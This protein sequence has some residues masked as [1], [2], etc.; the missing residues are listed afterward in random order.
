MIHRSIPSSYPSNVAQ[1]HLAD[2][3]AAGGPLRQPQYAEAPPPSA[4]TSPPKA[5]AIIQKIKAG[6]QEVR[7]TKCDVMAQEIG[8]RT[9]SI[10][11]ALGGR[12]GSG[13]RSPA[14]HRDMAAHRPAPDVAIE[15]SAACLG[16]QVG[17]PQEEEGQ[18]IQLRFAILILWVFLVFGI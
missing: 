15:C 5:K 13:M 7:E 6:A 11:A 12:A 16:G 17:L 3:G 1:V 4:S 9:H 8:Q 14:A 18:V 10:Q 2:C